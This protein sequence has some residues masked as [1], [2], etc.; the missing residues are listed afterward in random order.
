MLG[1]YQSR[2]EVTRVDVMGK[3]SRQVA[4]LAISIISI[5]DVLGEGK[6]SLR[7]RIS[8]LALQPFRHLA[9]LT[10]SV[11]HLAQASSRGSVRP[12]HKVHRL[13]VSTFTVRIIPIES[14]RRAYGSS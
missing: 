8:G 9:D 6:S 1:E 12:H 13:H 11:V 14:V 7:P 3:Q 4:V 10:V 2:S 5:S